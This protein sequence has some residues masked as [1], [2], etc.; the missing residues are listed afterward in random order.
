M[1]RSSARWP[2]GHPTAPD[3]GPAPDHPIGVAASASSLHP[4]SMAE[5][6]ERWADLSPRYR[7]FVVVGLAIFVVGGAALRIFV[8][9][10][11]GVRRFL[12]LS[13]V[14]IVFV[15]LRV[16]WLTRRKRW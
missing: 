5:D 13:V 10:G 8:V 1:C 6:D 16:A 2:A 12:E 9:E 7:L 4:V 3:A 11:E 14:L 15:L